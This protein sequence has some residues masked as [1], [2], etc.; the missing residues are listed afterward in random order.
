MVNLY[1]SNEIYQEK[2]FKKDEWIDISCPT[3]SHFSVEIVIV[4]E[5]EF[6]VE[7]DGTNY[8]LKQQQAMIIMSFE[9]HKFVTVNTSRVLILN[10]TPSFFLEYKTFLENKR[11]ENPVVDIPEGELSFILRHAADIQPNDTIEINC[12]FYALFSLFWKN[13][14]MVEAKTPKQLFRKAILYINEHYQEQITLKQLADELH[15]NYVYLSRVFNRDAHVGFTEFLNSF[16]VE[17]A[18]RLLKNTDRSASEIAYECGWGSIRNFN[19][20]FK[21]ALGCTPTEF[22]STVGS[23]KEWSYYDIP[24]IRELE[25]EKWVTLA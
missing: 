24:G 8:A 3:H 2:V 9:M 5:G 11:L 13:S 19:K 20:A 7:L 10:C 6:L 15:V 18:I 4:L 17:N 22:R 21:Q 25:Q 12:V 1:F 23:S 16:R 14:S